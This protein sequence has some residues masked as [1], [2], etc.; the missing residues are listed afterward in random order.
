MNYGGTIEKKAIWLN[1]KYQ[2]IIN[3]AITRV[4]ISPTPFTPLGMPRPSALFLCMKALIIATTYIK[5]IINATIHKNNINND[6]VYTGK[7]LS[8]TQNLII[9]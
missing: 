3:N 5:K 1:K 8:H 6:K 9:K 4:E 7:L 2:I